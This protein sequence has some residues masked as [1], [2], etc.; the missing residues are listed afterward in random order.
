MSPTSTA[1]EE[2]GRGT[3]PRFRDPNVKAVFDAYDSTR[4]DDLLHLR[5]LIFETAAEIEQVGELSETLKWGQPAYLPK[6]PRV[7]ST[8]RID[9][10]KSDTNRFA[11]FFHCQAN[12]VPHFREI[13][14]EKFR[15]QRNRALVFDHGDAIPTD[16]L[17]HCVA[18]A[19]TYH[20]RPR[21]VAKVG[22]R[23]RTRT[24]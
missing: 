15:F 5:H 21:S 23:P 20:K 11:M 10:L 1:S 14:P 22:A 12:L 3:T 13:Y 9:A 16:A 2:A 4:R 7:G 17:K 8:I 18:L 24:E 6:K 19:L